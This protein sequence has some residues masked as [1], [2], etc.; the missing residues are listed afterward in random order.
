MD[1]P[2]FI[3]EE[4]PHGRSGS[5]IKG[6]GIW[7]VLVREFAAS[8]IETA[9]VNTGDRDFKQVYASIS[10][11]IKVVGLS[12]KIRAVRRNNVSAVYLQRITDAPAGG[13][14][15]NGGNGHS[16]VTVDTDASEKVDAAFKHLEV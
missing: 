14:G 8:N 5:T 3:A 4:I 7:Q 10:H 6:A 12:D 13:N 15:H 2:T 11:A 16:A 1:K 9:K